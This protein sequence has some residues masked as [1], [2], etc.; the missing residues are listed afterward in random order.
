MHEHDLNLMAA[1]A[2]GS[3]EDDSEA[4]A[5][6]DT[7]DVCRSEYQAHARV[8]ELFAAT[9]K[10]S[11]TELEKAALHRDVW[12]ELRRAPARTT[13]APWWQRW[14]YVAAGL[15]VLVGL[16]GVLGRQL[17][18]GGETAETFAEI[19][20]GPE[21]APAD[22]EAAPFAAGD[23]A[24]DGGADS[25][26]TTTA[27]AAGTLAPSFPELADQARAKEADQSLGTMSVDDE[28]E[29]CLSRA[30][31]DEHIVVDEV[32]LDQTYLVAMPEDPE[33]DRIVTFVALAG[34]EVVYVD[35]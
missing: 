14:Y 19:G 17:P 28:V 11:M 24:D 12:T 30:G 3:L 33:A 21:S 23:S 31:L 20:S 26:A 13:S 10:D 35:R 6:V 8:L 29:E 18:G 27:A 2:D 34:C 5:L 16:V 25:G 15:F 4:L 22:E 32:E 7:C 1:L 9:P